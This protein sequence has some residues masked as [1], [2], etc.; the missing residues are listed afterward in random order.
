MFNYTC[1]DGYDNA[2]CD[3]KVIELIFDLNEIA[4]PDTYAAILQDDLRQ[5]YT[6]HSVEVEYTGLTG[7]D[8]LGTYTFTLTYTDQNE[9]HALPSS[10]QVEQSVIDSGHQSILVYTYTEYDEGG[11]PSTGSL[12]TAPATTLAVLMAIVMCLA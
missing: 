5:I 11:A 10:A 12:A 6:N 3:S 9:Q 2:L 7:Y 4:D 1:L 8:N